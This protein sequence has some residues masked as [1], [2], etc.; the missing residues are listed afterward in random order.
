MGTTGLRCGAFA[1]LILAVAVFGSASAADYIF[2]SLVVKGTG[3]RS[4]EISGQTAQ[5]PS[6]QKLTER[7]SGSG[8]TRDKTTLELD[9][10]QDSINYSREAEFEYFPTSYQTGTYDRKWSDFLCVKNYDAGA[11][12][13]ET[14]NQAEYL[15]KS[16]EVGSMGNLSANGLQAQISS[17]VIG[18]AHIGWYSKETE[19]GEKG[20]YIQ[21]GRSREDLIGV[22][23]IDKYIE[24]MQNSTNLGLSTQW[25]PCN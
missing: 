11:V 18:S 6:G 5:G 12:L 3:Y 17:K 15:Q 16:T 2:E 19:P 21:I 20:R 4:D 22:F 1:A 10:L 25:L 9:I 13:T 8:S 23:S 7:I 24:I 14:Y